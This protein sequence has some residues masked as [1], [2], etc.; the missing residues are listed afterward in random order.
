VG[1]EE[2]LLP[3]TILERSGPEVY[4]VKGEEGGGGF[5]TNNSE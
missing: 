5:I 3:H 2:I 4:I 1:M